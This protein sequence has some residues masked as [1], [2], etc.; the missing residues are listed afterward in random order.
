MWPLC[1][2]KAVSKYVLVSPRKARLMADVIRNQKVEVAMDQLRFAENK[3][4]RLLYKTLASA[5]ANAETLHQVQRREMRVC[6]VR[7]DGGPMMKRGKSQSRGR[8]VPIMKRT[9]HLS[10]SVGKVDPRKMK[11]E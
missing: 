6:E 1:Y 2:G 5:L 11:E 8:R 10:V 3:A 7:V 9:S 4:G